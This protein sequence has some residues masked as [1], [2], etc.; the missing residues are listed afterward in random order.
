MVRKVF[1]YPLSNCTM[2]AIHRATTSRLKLQ[3][4]TRDECLLQV[5]G[6]IG[7]TLFKVPGFKYIYTL[8][9]YYYSMTILQDSIVLLTSSIIL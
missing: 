2:N 1:L 6:R 4:H 3:G 8:F 5:I 7:I 9:K